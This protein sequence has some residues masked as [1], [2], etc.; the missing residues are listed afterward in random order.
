MDRRSINRRKFI[1]L[2]ALSAGGALT[3][4]CGAGPEQQNGQRGQYIKVSG[5]NG[6]EGVLDTQTGITAWTTP[7]IQ[8]STTSVPATPAGPEPTEQLVEPTAEQEKQKVDKEENKEQKPRATLQQYVQEIE[9][10]NLSPSEAIAYLGMAGYAGRL[11]VRQFDGSVPVHFNAGDLVSVNF[12]EGE[13]PSG[14]NWLTVNEAGN[15]GVGIAEQDIDFRTVM[16]A[17]GLIIEGITGDFMSVNEAN[18]IPIERAGTKGVFIPRYQLEDWREWFRNATSPNREAL[19]DA[20]TEYTN[21]TKNRKVY[22]PPG[23]EFRPQ[24]D[25]II[26]ADWGINPDTGEPAIPPGVVPLSTR[27]DGIASTHG[28]WGTWF[29]PAGTSLR[30]LPLVG[31]GV[32]I[33]VANE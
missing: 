29:A 19:F 21:R 26:L 4:G 32:A 6:E 15:W 11:D 14:F 2:A 9:R 3:A 17:S 24:L 23:R 13:V 5:P 12:H 7:S 16:P 22:L 30:T 33:L 25:C 18:S 10:L 27:D 31:S 8:R 20:V 1:K 28:G